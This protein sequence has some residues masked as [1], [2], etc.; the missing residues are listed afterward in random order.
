MIKICFK[1]F[2]YVFIYVDFLYNLGPWRDFSSFFLSN[3]YRDGLDGLNYLKT[4]RGWFIEIYQG[5]RKLHCSIIVVY[6]NTNS[7]YDGI[8]SGKF[9]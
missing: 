8:T 7:E 5:P 9:I 6:L 2:L 4:M 1:L 3:K